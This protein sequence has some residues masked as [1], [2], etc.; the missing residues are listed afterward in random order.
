MNMSEEEMKEYAAKMY[1]ITIDYIR[2]YK[3]CL[4]TQTGLL[5]MHI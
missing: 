1:Q 4:Y 2:E 5:A 3:R